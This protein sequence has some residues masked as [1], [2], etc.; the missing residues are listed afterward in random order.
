[1]KPKV[2]AIIDY[3]MGNLYS[4]QR[5]CQ[6]VG[7]SSIITNDKEIL[8]D[9]DAVILPGVG[10]FGDAM[11]TL[12]KLDLVSAIHEFVKT[13]RPFIGICLG[14]Q[15]LFTE[16]EEFGQHKGLD[17]IHGSVVR[18]RG[19]KTRVPQM[20][21]NKVFYKNN[22]KDWGNLFMNGIQNGEYM[23]FV[24]SYYPVPAESKLPILTTKYGGI[25]YCS[26][27]S[28]GNVLGVQFHPE[29]SGKEGINLYKNLATYI[30]S[31]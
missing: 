27:I 29:K 11:E 26:G 31:L 13:G 1:M 15:L 5:A 28:L 6:F 8:K 18:F 12:N 14:F 20:G 25:E 9:A 2:V 7:L 16:S 21:W 4:V 24:H 23:Y 17:I 22:G 30:N 19:R 3:G 10:A